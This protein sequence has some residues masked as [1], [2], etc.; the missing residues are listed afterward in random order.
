MQVLEICIYK[1][2]I[3]FSQLCKNYYQVI[4]ISLSTL[5]TKGAKSFVIIN[6]DMNLKCLL[7]RKKVWVLKNYSIFISLIMKQF[8]KL[9]KI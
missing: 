3:Y 1:K 4:N 6:V 5:T 7:K 2:K 9:F 8:L